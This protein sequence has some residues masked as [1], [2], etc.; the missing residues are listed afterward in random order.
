MRKRVLITGG[1]GYLAKSIKKHFER[2]Y[3]VTTISRK[4]F[5][6]TIQES[7]NKFFDFSYRF[8]VVIHCAV[9]GGSRLKKDD[10][11]IMDDNLKMYYNLLNNKEKFGKLIHFGSG[12]EV[13]KSNEPYG[14]SKKVIA[15]SMENKIDFY[16]IRIYAVFDENELDSRFIKTCIINYINK[17]PIEIHQ[18]KFMDFFYMKDL[19]KVIEYYIESHN[20]IYN[21]FE[22][23]YRNSS[24]TL[25]DIANFINALSD[26]KVEIRIH[27]EGFSEEYKAGYFPIS[28]VETE[29]IGLHNGIIETYNKIYEKNKL[30]NK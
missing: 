9:S 7:C 11:S 15:K 24:V 8:D 26:H 13:F 28:S 22:C 25:L 20:P 27:N 10:W 29:Y 12:A 18:N 16:N 17:K 14:M 2:I 21:N 5:D 6:L 3:D 23:S 1:N 30:S 19:L 4:D